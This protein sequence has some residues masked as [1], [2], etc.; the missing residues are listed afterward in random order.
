[1]A[2]IADA[3]ADWHAVHGWNAGCPLDCAAADVA[4]WDEGMGDDLSPAEVAFVEFG[5]QPNADP[6]PPW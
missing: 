6:E 4:G 2:W 3:H 1:M 5:T